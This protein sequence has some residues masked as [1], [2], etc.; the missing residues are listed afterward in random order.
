MVSNKAYNELQMNTIFKGLPSTYRFKAT[1]N[2]MS[3]HLAIYESDDP[4]V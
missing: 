4:Q 3:T 2:D 1:K